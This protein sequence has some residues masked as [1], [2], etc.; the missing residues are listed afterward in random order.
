MKVRSLQ[1]LPTKKTRRHTFQTNDVVGYI[2][3]ALFARERNWVSCPPARPLALQ[4]NFLRWMNRS[5]ILRANGANNGARI[6][7][8]AAYA[9]NE[10]I[11]AIHL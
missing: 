6:R 7:N 4:P 10:D 5:K 8:C 1:K 2:G 3:P 11:R 9:C